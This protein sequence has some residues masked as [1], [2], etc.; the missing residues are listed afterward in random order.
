M[1]WQGKSVLLTGVTGFVGSRLAGHLVGQGADVHGFFRPRSANPVPVVTGTSKRIDPRV[2]LIPGDLRDRRSLVDALDASQPE[3]IF[4]L[5]AQSFVPLSLQD[6]AETYATNLMGSLNLL[7]AVRLSGL[8]PFF[9]YAGS[10]EEY[11]VAFAS[12]RQYDEFVGRHGRSF[13]GPV[14]MPELPIGEDNPL[15]PMS[16]HAL[17]KVQGDYL[18][19]NYALCWGIPAVVSRAFNHEGPG[20]G[21]MFVT[22]VITSQAAKIAAGASRGLTIGNVNSFRDW[23]HVD[24][25]V[26]GYCLLV[27]KGSPGEVYNLGSQRTNSVLTYILL[28]LQEAGLEVRAIESAK[29]NSRVIDPL[30]WDTDP[31]WG[32]DFGKTRVDRL[33][34]EG[35]LAFGLEDEGIRVHTDSAEVDISFDPS[36]FRSQDVP[37]LL[38][39]VSKARRLGL[40][41]GHSLSDIVRCQV[42]YYLDSNA[43]YGSGEPG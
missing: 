42:E 7:E 36:R 10:S 14:S 18:T 13:A 29:G 21:P 8:S 15:R 12:Q 24:D 33:M 39:D 35:E 20:R 28:A 32:C 5:G 22:S 40:K 16:P 27:E 23:S 1:N 26:R 19:R 38:A 37:V 4:H 43:C 25:I 31:M 30:A 6:P 34:L 41:I 11:G 2:R 9:V 17:S 3:V